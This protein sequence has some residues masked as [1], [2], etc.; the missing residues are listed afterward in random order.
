MAVNVLSSFKQF[1]IPVPT[2][3]KTM[4][5]FQRLAGHCSLGKF[6]VLVKIVRKRFI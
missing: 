5:P 6:P 4:T 1:K 3:R 2:W